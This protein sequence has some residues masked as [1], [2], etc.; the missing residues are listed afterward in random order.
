MEEIAESGCGRE[1]ELD[2]KEKGGEKRGRENTEEL[3]A[4]KILSEWDIKLGKII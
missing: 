2:R 4:S 1:G 3:L